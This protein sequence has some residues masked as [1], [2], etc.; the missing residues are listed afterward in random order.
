[1]GSR[2]T[3]ADF[4]NVYA[5]AG[6]WVDRALRT[7][8]SLFT[9]GRPIWSKT[10]L[11]ELRRR[12]L[13]RPDQGEGGF[14]SKLRAQLEDSP[15][16]VYQLMA[17]VLYAQFLIIWKGT[18]GGEMKRKQIERVLG[19][20]A[21][22]STIPGELAAGL[23][24][25]IAGSPSF[26]Y[27]RQN[28]AAFVIEFAERWKEQ[29]GE[30]RERCLRDPWAFK[31]F[32]TGINFRSILL[33]GRPNAAASQRE[34]VL[35]LVHPDAFEGTV[36]VEQKEE[37]A[38]TRAFAH[39]V[40]EETADVDRRLAQIRRGLE[41]GLGRDVDFYDERIRR[42][43]DSSVR[44]AEAI[45]PWDAYLGSGSGYLDSGKLW[46]EELDYKYEIGRKLSAAREA[47]LDGADDWADLVKEGIEGNIIHFIPQDNFRSWLDGSP[48]EAR[49][50][51]R[52]LWTRDAETLE[53]RVRA[54]CPQFPESVTRGTGTRMNIISQLLMGLDVE[55]YPPFRITTF[56]DAY[57]RTGYGR[58]E[59]DPD[60]A[61]LYRYAL[62][63]LDRLISEARAR[64]LPVRHRLDAQ[65]LLWMIP[66]W[67]KETGGGQPLPTDAE[68]QADRHPPGSHPEPPPVDL[69]GLASE[70]CLTEPPDFL[71]Q[72]E[73][74]LRDK[75]QVIFQGPPGTGKT[76]V[77]RT[78]AEHLAG[79]ARR[80]T[81]VQMH[82]SYAYEDF[83]QGF[84]P[85]LSGGQAGFELRDGPLLRAAEFARQE[86]GE[87][88]FLVID[89]INRGNIARVFGELYFLLEYRDQ[90]MR[91]QYQGGGEEDFSLPSNLHIIGTMNTADRSIALVDLALRRRFH[92]VEFH[93]ESEPVKGLLRRWLS[94]KAPGMEWVAGVVERANE[95]LGDDRHAAIGPSHFMRP[96]LA[97]ADVERIWK[98][99]VLPYI[100]ERRFGHSDGLDEFDL[101]A[102]RR[103]GGAGEPPDG[104]DPQPGNTD[105]AGRGDGGEEQAAR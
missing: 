29:A 86:P 46:E 84:R 23:T 27:Q 12:F 20:G 28:H 89:E 41:A 82:P 68:E 40:T 32:V 60:E 21:P 5:A 44:D 81:L 4:E 76:Y 15:P 33:R 53:G 35:H 78:L 94:E 72:I 79:S 8:D 3:G 58:P 57:D 87:R 91:L 13:E 61:S 98:H 95:L 88:H 34:A 22:V 26:N 63:F 102:L 92:F 70:L 30:E 17:E 105:D 97:Q 38:G 56:T 10:W 75:G 85:T 39:F 64:D 24:P 77:A 80:V 19:W 83:V 16:E 25:G 42:R 62:G 51:L 1:M 71:H 50:A 9:P 69:S 93:P 36:S 65:S 99:S 67:E 73:A 14:L 52:A 104:G 101:G 54:F 55:R 66:I 45:D 37:I 47:T 18:M 11:E 2:K 49:A 90:R 48:H 74:L 96:G 103:A 100:E 59:D 43:W 7:D 6:M 31:D